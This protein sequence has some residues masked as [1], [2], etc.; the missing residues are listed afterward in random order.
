[1]I[2]Y[3]GFFMSNPARRARAF[4]CL[5]K[6]VS[7]GKVKMFNSAGIAAI[8]IAIFSVLAFCGGFIVGNWRS[9]SQLHQLSSL[10]TILSA[11]NEK[12]TADIQSVRAAMAVMT[13]TIA[14]REKKAARAMQ[15]ATAAAATHTSRAKKIR[16]LPEVPAEHQYEVIAREQI[17]YVQSRLQDN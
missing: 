17:E 9:T 10:N 12:C 11:A 16:S 2:N 5:L 8:V 3:P 15:Q 4:Y 1:M 6:T 14:A 13:T 7:R